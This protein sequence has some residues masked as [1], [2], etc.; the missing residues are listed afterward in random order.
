MGRFQLLVVITYAAL[1]IG[2]LVWLRASLEATSGLVIPLAWLA[3]AVVLVTVALSGAMT[4]LTAGVLAATRLP[5]WLV[6]VISL[7]AGPLAAAGAFFCIRTF[8]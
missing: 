7:A 4:L 1:I 3:G 5:L 2:G 8:T 6:V